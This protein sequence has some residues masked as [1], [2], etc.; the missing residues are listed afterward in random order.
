MKKILVVGVVLM[1]LGVTLPTIS[2]LSTIKAQP[3][4]SDLVT[5]NNFPSNGMYWN[6]HKINSYTS[7]LFVHLRGGF[8][9]QINFNIT[10]NDI[11]KV[12]IWTEYGIRLQSNTPPY[13]L[14]LT[15]IHLLPFSHTATYTTKV[16]LNNGLIISDNYSV[17]R[18]F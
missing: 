14:Y 12:E 2:N 16:Y 10:G 9:P 3:V 5:I 11:S 17:S 6:D 13:N 15:G 18:L 7:P 4:K 1:F 8:L